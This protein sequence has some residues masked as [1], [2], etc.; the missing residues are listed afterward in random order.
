M[1]L[2]QFYQT[3]SWAL[4]EKWFILLTANPSGKDYFVQKVDQAIL[5][6]MLHIEVNFDTLEMKTNMHFTYQSDQMT[7]ESRHSSWGH[8]TKTG[9]QCNQHI[10]RACPRQQ[11]QKLQ[12]GRDCEATGAQR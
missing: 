4:P 2:F 6:R 5:D 1:E 10:E 8:Q 11:R 3:S 7:K 12:R 9:L